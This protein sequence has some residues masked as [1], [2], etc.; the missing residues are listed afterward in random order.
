MIV[1]DRNNFRGIPVPPSQI[2]GFKKRGLLKGLFSRSNKPK[3]SQRF[4]QSKFGQNAKM[5]GKQLGQEFK[6]LGKEALLEVKDIAHGTLQDVIAE[7]E[8]KVRQ[9][10]T[11]FVAGIPGLN[12][13]QRRIIEQRYAQQELEDELE[14]L[15]TVGVDGDQCTPFTATNTPGDQCR[16]QGFDGYHRQ[17]NECKNLPKGNRCRQM[18]CDGWLPR[19]GS[20][21]RNVKLGTDDDCLAAQFDIDDF[22]CSGTDRKKALLTFHP[23]KNLDCRDIATQKFEM[24]QNKCVE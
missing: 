7:A 18:G 8:E 15:D 20:C 3:L 6:T 19:T 9:E 4:K 24:Y 23:D 16:A 21:F 5:F 2:G 22:E 11:S 12:E 14:D 1:D 17:T 10:A 13:A